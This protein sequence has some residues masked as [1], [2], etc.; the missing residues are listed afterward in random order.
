MAYLRFYKRIPVIPGLIY[1]NL[2]KGGFS[3]LFG[4][5]YGFTITVGHGRIRFTWG[6]SGSGISVSE[7]VYFKGGEEKEPEKDYWD[8]KLEAK[9]E[10]DNAPE[11][12]D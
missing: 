7:N 2:A 11:K 9:M 10:I 3:L 6:L 8:R 4:R 5:V 1:L 12:D